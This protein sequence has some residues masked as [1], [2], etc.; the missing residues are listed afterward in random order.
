VT[1]HEFLEAPHPA[2]LPTAGI[3]R[4]SARPEPE[5]LSQPPRSVRLP[6][7]QDPHAVPVDD[8]PLEREGH[9]PIRSERPPSSP[10][11]RTIRRPT[12]TSGSRIPVVAAADPVEVGLF[13]DLEAGSVEAARTLIGRLETHPERTH[14]L[15]AVC[16]KLAMLQP[17]NRWALEKLYAAASA[18][19]DYGYARAIEHVLKTGID[20][21]P[22]IESPSL[23]ELGEDPE[24]VRALLLRDAN[25]PALEAL[26]LV[27]EAAEHVFRRDPTAYGVTGLERVPL[28]APTSLGRA[29]AITARALGMSKTPL[30]LR[31][32]LAAPSVSVA[33]MSPPAVIV[34]GEVTQE[35]NELRYHLG[36][37]L[38]GALPQHVLVYGSPETEVRAVLR[39]LLLVFGPPGVAKDG[40]VA[41]A[42]LAEVLWESVPARSQRRLRELC[43]QES[44]FEYDLVV[45]AAHQATR[46][47][48]LFACGDLRIAVREVCAAEGVDFGA[49][50]ARDG[51]EHL[52]ASSASIADLV[53]LATSPTYAQTRWGSRN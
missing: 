24:S 10:R 32:T 7:P 46:R 5:H 38:A 11:V 49:L 14:D 23:Q 12:P 8:E 28:N 3:G 22:A 2:E 35:S 27:W 51:L 44:D 4:Y 42:N 43:R 17:G 13:A 36:A 39:A 34:S 26:G 30:F 20:P 37:M 40:I 25:A 15:S 31:R 16:R 53:T 50:L 21:D 52:C 33:L 47:A 9:A 41:A 45:A 19:H 18:D 1:P 48:G 6:V 29:Y